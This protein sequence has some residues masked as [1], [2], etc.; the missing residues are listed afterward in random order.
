MVAEEVAQVQATGLGCCKYGFFSHSGFTAQP[1][2][3]TVLIDLKDI[4]EG[5]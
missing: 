2:E 1:D 5:I 4:Y 3:R